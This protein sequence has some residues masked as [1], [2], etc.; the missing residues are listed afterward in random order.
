MAA[1]ADN[2][3]AGAVEPMANTADH[4]KAAL[5]QIATVDDQMIADR[6]TPAVDKIATVGDQM[7]AVVGHRWQLMLN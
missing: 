2:H 6:M 3:M 4:M 1:A 7:I 5:D